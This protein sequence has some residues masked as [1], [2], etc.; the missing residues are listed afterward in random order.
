[1]GPRRTGCHNALA[2]LN[3][4]FRSFDGFEAPPPKAG[5]SKKPTLPIMLL[6]QRCGLD[7]EC[8]SLLFAN[9]NHVRQAPIERVMYIYVI[10]TSFAVWRLRGTRDFFF[11]A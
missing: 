11:C 1:M 2:S 10:Q 4:A 9:T 6:Y 8:R 7:F 5:K 3:Q